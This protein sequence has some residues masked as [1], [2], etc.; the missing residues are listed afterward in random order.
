[1]RADIMAYALVFFWWKFSM[2]LR[3]NTVIKEKKQ[4]FLT[5]L[6]NFLFDLSIPVLK[7][8]QDIIDVV[9]AY[10]LSGYDALYLGLARAKQCK[11][12]SL[13]K[14]LLRVADWV[15]TPAKAVG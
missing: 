4:K 8:I 14:K 2:C 13:D 1:M 12:I 7:N 10:T 5:L 11:L 15:I 6:R 9:Y 3:I